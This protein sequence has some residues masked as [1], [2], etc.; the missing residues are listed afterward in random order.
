MIIKSAYQSVGFVQYKKQMKV[1]YQ[2]GLVVFSFD[3][4]LNS[5]NKVFST[6]A[7]DRLSYEM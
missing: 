1:Q 6:L 4:D 3:E 5:L 7:K 2:A